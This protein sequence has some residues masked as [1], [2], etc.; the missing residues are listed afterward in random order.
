[1]SPEFIQHFW[2]GVVRVVELTF[3]IGKEPKPKAP[4]WRSIMGPIIRNGITKTKKQQR[5]KQFFS[6]FNFKAQFVKKCPR[7]LTFSWWGCYG[8]CLRHK[9]IE[10]AHSLYSVLVSDF[11]AL[12]TVFHSINSPDN[13]ALSL[14]FWSYFCCIG[15]FNYVSLFKSF[16]SPDTIFCG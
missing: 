8:L 2:H 7:G 16:P 9:P 14:F 4:K 5:P 6:Q 11:M 1:M 10:L 3:A 12:S 13:S 15:P